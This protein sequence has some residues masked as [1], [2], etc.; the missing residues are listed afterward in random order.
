MLPRLTI[1]ALIMAQTKALA[2]GPEESHKLIDLFHLT[3]DNREAIYEPLDAKQKQFRLL[4]LQAGRASDIISCSIQVASLSDDPPPQYETISYCWG[5]PEPNVSVNI[6]GSHLKVPTNAALAISRMRLPDRYRTLW[7]DAVCINQ[8]DL[9]ERAQQV[10]LMKDIYGEGTGNLIYLGEEESWT[11]SALKSIRLVL[12]DI[13][14]ETAN[15]EDLVKLLLEPTGAF[16]RSDIPMGVQVDFA[17][18]ETFW[19]LPYFKY[20]FLSCSWRV[21]LTRFQTGVDFTR[22]TTVSVKSLLSRVL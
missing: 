1:V 6:N 7:I 21:S 13:E 2:M 3:D 10:L 16:K 19:G 20:V 11:A 22:N 15:S 17:S 18:L 9:D 14:R 4:H 12:E 5:D 8:A